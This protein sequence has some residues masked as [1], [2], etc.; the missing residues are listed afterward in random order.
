M[1]GGGV[2]SMAVEYLTAELAENTKYEEIQEAYDT[3]DLT[4]VVD[5]GVWYFEGIVDCN[6]RTLVKKEMS[7]LYPQ[8]IYIHYLPYHRKE[9]RIVL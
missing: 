5:D 9:R 4:V 7:R 1:F 2:R 6:I 8:Y 3:N